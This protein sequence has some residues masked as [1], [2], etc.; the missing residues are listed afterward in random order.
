MENNSIRSNQTGVAG[1]SDPNNYSAI[2]SQ[3]SQGGGAIPTKQYYAAKPYEF[4]HR[5]TLNQT[6]IVAGSYYNT[7]AGHPKSNHTIII[8]FIETFKDRL[9]MKRSY[10]KNATA[11]TDT[12]QSLKEV[13]QI[14]GKKAQLNM[15]PNFAILNDSLQFE[16]QPA[17][18]VIAWRHTP[19]IV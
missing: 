17:N 15:K 8:V 11:M 3:N 18:A 6:V 1:P 19:K 14:H 16:G 12:Q 4:K 5:E 9:Y 13:S 10:G 7:T 2:Y